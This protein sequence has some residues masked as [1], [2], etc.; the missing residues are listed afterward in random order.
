MHHETFDFAGWQH[1]S[2]GITPSPFETMY[3]VGAGI[4]GP[5]DVCRL[6]H[7]R[8]QLRAEFDFGPPIPTDVFVFARGEPND[9]G[10]TKVGGLPYRPSELGWPRTTSVLH[11]NGELPR[12]TSWS[13]GD[14]N[15]T[16]GWRNE[17]GPGLLEF[18][19]GVDGEEQRDEDYPCL[20]FL[21]QFNFCDS[22]DLV[23]GLPG[24]V[25]LLFGIW[26]WPF[27]TYYEWH[28]AGLTDL[29][30]KAHVPRRGYRQEPDEHFDRRVTC[31]GQIHRTCD[32]PEARTNSA[33]DEHEIP[34][35][36]ELVF[37]P[38]A[39]RIGGVPRYIQG[40]P[41]LPGTLLC[42]FDGIDP[43]WEDPWPWLNVEETLCDELG[44]WEAK[45]ENEN[46]TFID[47]SASIYINIDGEG[48][49]HQCHQCT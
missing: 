5:L 44:K 23:G 8:G 3:S 49:L 38:K 4:V 37:Q 43:S 25:L 7:L 45:D 1:R 39:H 20:R 16:L 13:G 30:S 18:Y 34:R 47:C 11:P 32:Y 9:R 33:N 28:K 29:I 40:D 19:E 24:D 46:R 42:V 6:E 2:A 15:V 27:V 10:V 41:E 35:R 12:R 36:Y 26:E 17:V 14:P 22:K 21:G 31:Y 48:N